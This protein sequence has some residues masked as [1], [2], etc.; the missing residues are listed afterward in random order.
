M[1]SRLVAHAIV[2]TM[3]LQI[4][5]ADGKPTLARTPAAKS[6]GAKPSKT[7][8]TK[9]G[10]GKPIKAEARSEPAP[11]SGGL[12]DG[13]APGEP[14]GASQSGP[15]ATS[16]GKSAAAPSSEAPAPD[17]AVAGA[18]PAESA[19]TPIAEH[20]QKNPELP[21]DRHRW[22]ERGITMQSDT[23][24]AA[25]LGLGFGH[26]SFLTVSGVDRNASGF[27]LNFDAVVGLRRTV[28]LGVRF[29]LRF[30]DEASVARADYYGRAGDRET[31]LALG[32]KSV[33]NPELRGRFRV[34]D[35]ESF[36]LAVEGRFLV[37]L[38]NG[39][40]VMLGAPIQLRTGTSMRIDTG[41]FVPLTFAEAKTYVSVSVPVRAWYQISESFFAGPLTGLRINSVK[42]RE[43]DVPLGI[44]VG[45]SIHR[46]ID[47]KGDFYLNR[48]N[49]GFREFGFGIGI[50]FHTE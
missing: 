26:A 43:I 27:G 39:A 50:G 41:M 46:T 38:N 10:K 24:V 21:S 48:V 33:A 32:F 29:G 6:K 18:D 40:T 8:K 49:N 22:I 4:C 13:P 45:V 47:L 11:A 37:P 23:G 2:A 3:F 25:D 31:Y 20:A 16:P 9:K 19:E 5:S 14:A 12:S 28:D 34:L 36:A 30:G 1:N 7:E 17:A 44:G 35:K 15:Q 42:G